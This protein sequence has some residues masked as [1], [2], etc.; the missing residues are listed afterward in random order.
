MMPATCSTMVVVPPGTGRVALSRPMRRDSPPASTTPASDAVPDTESTTSVDGPG[1]A[2]TQK[3]LQRGGVRRGGRLG[4][5]HLRAGRVVVGGSAD[6][7]ENSQHGVVEV[8]VRQP[9]QRE[10]VCRVVAVRVVHHDL[11]DGD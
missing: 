9:G 11:F 5:V 4:G 6:V 10:R 8:L 1:V 2:P 7:P 3:R